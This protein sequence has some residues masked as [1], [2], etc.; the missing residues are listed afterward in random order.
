M[1]HMSTSQP[2]ESFNPIGR[3]SFFSL[4]RSGQQNAN[5]SLD[6]VS[7]Y[8]AISYVWGDLSVQISIIEE[9]TM[10]A[11]L[12][13][14]VALSSTSCNEWNG[15]GLRGRCLYQSREPRGTRSASKHYEHGLFESRWNP[16]LTWYL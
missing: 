9:K 13:L 7:S 1:N 3:A 11:T 6:S 8:K 10:S 15:R 5:G 2:S 4:E 14:K 12:D 16:R